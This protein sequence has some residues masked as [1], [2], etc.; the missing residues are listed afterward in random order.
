MIDYDNHVKSLT[1]QEFP[2]ERKE[3]N[4][5]EDVVE[6]LNNDHIPV[7]STIENRKNILFNKNSFRS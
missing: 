3:Y 6:I 4:K 7:D 2:A 5:F 1:E